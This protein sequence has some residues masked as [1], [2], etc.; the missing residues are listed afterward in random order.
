MASTNT[1]NNAST[2]SGWLKQI[3]GEVNDVRPDGVKFTKQ[4]KFS[5]SK[6]MGEKYVEPVWLSEEQGFTYDAG[7]SGTG[8]DLND[9]EAAISQQLQLSGA[10]IVLTSKVGLAQFSRAVDAGK[11]SFGNFYKR[12]LA[13]MASSFKKR[14]EVVSIYGGTSIGKASSVSAATT[15][16]TITMNT[17]TYAPGIWAGAKNAKLDAYNGATKLNTGGDI[18]V[19]SHTPGSAPTIAIS[20]A[21]ADITAINSA[22]SSTEFYYKGAY[23]NEMTG[24]YTIAGQTS[25]TYANISPSTYD[26]WQGNAISVGTADLT[27]DRIQDGVESAVG[28]GLD[29]SIVLYVPLPAWSALNSDLNG[30]RMLDSSY[31]KEKNEF[32][33]ESIVYHTLCG[34]VRVEPS[35]YIKYGD[36]FAVPEDADYLSRIGST[37]IT[38]EIPGQGG[39]YFMVVPGKNAVEFRAYTDQALL[40]RAPSKC[41]QWS[42]IVSS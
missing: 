7:T 4:V 17:T 22:G 9:S 8:F 18:K 42:G 2:A 30:L 38:F 28:R 16:A 23:G 13:N 15:T 34:M 29:E 39:E 14:V 40:C 20:G 6:K 41:I 24:I 35:I 11:Q 26:L 10:E 12:L 19:T 25:T 32:G 33:Q 21:A 27:W 5:A 36:A 1:Y 31:R 3:T 37:D